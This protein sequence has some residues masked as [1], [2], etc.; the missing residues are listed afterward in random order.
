MAR[1]FLHWK[2]SLKSAFLME[3]GRSFFSSMITAQ[4]TLTACAAT[5]AIAAPTASRWNP[6]TR[7]RSPMM[8]TTQATSTKIRGDRLS[9]RPRKRAESI[10]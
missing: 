5:V 1:N 8:L 3:K 4:T 2:F 7:T 9:P 10:L 6:A